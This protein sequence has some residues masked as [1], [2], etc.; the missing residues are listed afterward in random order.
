M[1]K[2]PFTLVAGANVDVWA[3]YENVRQALIDVITSCRA[4][5]VGLS[6][7]VVLHGEVGTGKSHALR[8]LQQYITAARR[9]EFRSACV[10]LESTKL[11]KKTD[12]VAVYRRVMEA[13]RSH[14]ED[15]ANRLDAAMDEKARATGMARIQ[16]VQAEKERLWNANAEAL[17]PQ[18]PSLIRLLH[19]LVEDDHAFSVLCG[20]DSGNLDDYQLTGPIDSEYDA[21]RCLSAYVNLVT[22]PNRDVLS[23]A[24]FEANRAFYLFIDEVELLQDFKPAEVLSINQGVRDLINGCPQAFCLIFGVSGDPR[25]LFG[26]FDKFV[27]RRFSRDPIEIQALDVAESV[28]FLKEVLRNYRLDPSDPDEYPFREAALHRIAEKTQDKTA[29]LLFRSSRRVL[30]RAILTDQLKP[31][32]WIEVADVDNLLA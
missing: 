10:Y 26:I 6:E 19:G 25:I 16:D 4:D 7:F 13:L 3:D 30:E 2:N 32:G 24:T 15:T 8:Y 23:E 9:D 18:F 29:A 28:R 12:F 14:V 21:S 31:G 22:N 17:A 11:A 20:N 1:K 27:V 5:Q